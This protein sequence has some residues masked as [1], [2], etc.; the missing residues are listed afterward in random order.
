MIVPPDWDIK[1]PRKVIGDKTVLSR[2]RHGTGERQT[3]Q[4]SGNRKK[5]KWQKKSDRT[6]LLIYGILSSGHAPFQPFGFL[7]G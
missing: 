7:G 6:I 3:P 4:D 5:Y 1:K 2:L